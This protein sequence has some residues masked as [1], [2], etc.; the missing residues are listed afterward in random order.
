[1]IFAQNPV[2]PE[3]N[4]GIQVHCSCIPKILYLFEDKGDVFRHLNDEMM[5]SICQGEEN[6]FQNHF[7]CFA[8]QK[9]KKSV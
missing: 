2:Q 9:K 4:F 6:I 7:F 1:M 3:L 8:D 5:V